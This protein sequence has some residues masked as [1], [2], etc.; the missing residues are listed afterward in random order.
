LWNNNV[1]TTKVFP[2]LTADP[3]ASPADQ[4][5]VLTCKAAHAYITNQYVTNADV[6][7]NWLG[8]IGEATCNEAGYSCEAFKTATGEFDDAAFAGSFNVI[9]DSIMTSDVELDKFLINRALML[10]LSNLKASELGSGDALISAVTQRA[11]AQITA[12]QALQQTMFEKMMLPLMTFFEALMYV[13]APFA[14]ILVAFGVGGLGMIGK[15]LIF[16]LWVQLWKPVA[17]VGNMFVQ[18]SVSGEMQNLNKFALDD[19]YS[20]ASI[21]N[22]PEVFDALQHW[23]GVGGM[24]VASTPAITLMLMYGS[25]VTASGLASRIDM[26]KGATVG[27]DDFNGKSQVGDA[28]MS[29][30]QERGQIAA[31]NEQTHDSTMGA[32]SMGATMGRQAQQASSLASS[33]TKKAETSRGQALESI[34]SAGA[35]IGQRNVA[36]STAKGGETGSMEWSKSEAARLVEQGQI[37]ETEQSM[38]STGINAKV[39][40][41]LN[42]G[43]ALTELGKKG[44]NTSGVKGAGHLGM[45]MKA[46]DGKVEAG[47]EYQ[48]KFNQAAA[49]T[50]SLTESVDQAWANAQ[51]EGRAWERSSSTTAEDSIT[52][53]DEWKDAEKH[54][55]QAQ[56]STARAESAENRASTLRSL[57]GSSGYQQDYKLATLAA[58]AGTPGGMKQF[59]EFLDAQA[60]QG[61]STYAGL[62]ANKSDYLTAARAAAAN[63]KTG[64]LAE[65]LGIAGKSFDDP[66]PKEEV[67][68]LKKQMDDRNPDGPSAGMAPTASPD[69]TSIAPVSRD[70]GMGI[71]SIDSTPR[72][73]AA[74]N[75]FNENPDASP[76]NISNDGAQALAGGGFEPVEKDPQVIADTISN[77]MENSDIREVDGKGKDLMDFLDTGIL[78]QAQERSTQASAAGAM[79]GSAGGAAYGAATA[80]ALKQG[81]KAV[82]MGLVRGAAMGLFRGG[83]W[84]AVAGAA[85]GAAEGYM[86]YRDTVEQGQKDQAGKELSGALQGNGDFSQIS[87]ESEEVINNTLQG[88]IAKQVTAMDQAARNGEEFDVE[89]FRNNELDDFERQVHD[90]A[91]TLMTA[92]DVRSDG[93]S[94][95]AELGDTLADAIDNAGDE[96]E[97]RRMGFL[98]NRY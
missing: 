12:N 51:K 98:T 6:I 67:G 68:A 96:K 75:F 14:A 2:Y 90:S 62:S 30:T 37:S 44:V 29:L 22:Q 8:N 4:P 23:I 40:G 91:D 35:S 3:T 82:A 64:D 36:G 94:Y 33:E 59:G 85:W 32:I 89:A 71:G 5:Q 42:L 1:Y 83:A 52:Q 25:A 7:N 79:A 34:T 87:N 54:T 84:G 76:D 15:Y 80:V 26:G 77:A 39:S 65:L 46:L 47:A 66:M 69:G 19:G 48:D 56:E 16:A 45:I 97:A 92:G 70:G 60:R 38:V 78:Q 74:T 10:P 27:M 61:D 11:S 53:T 86:A 88:V 81:G 73:D 20:L 57:A 13:A 41:G 9:R 93:Q 49:E 95:G 58:D 24:L 63:G 31:G 55:Q 50:A 43:T 21:A 72:D 17:A 18:M 28:K